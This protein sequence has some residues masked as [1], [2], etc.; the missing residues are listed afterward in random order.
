MHL[1]RVENVDNFPTPAVGPTQLQW[2]PVG[3]LD[4]IFGRS[5][6]PAAD[7]DALFAV[8]QA[9]L[10]LQAH[11]HEPAGLGSLCYRGSEGPAF[12]QAERDV[13]SLLD[14]DEGE[15]VERTRDQHGYS[16]L[17]IRH[18]PSDTPGLITDLHGANRGLQDAGFGTSLLCTV[19]N[20]RTHDE[21]PWGLVYLYKQGTFY[22]FVPGAE[23]RRDNQTELQINALIDND[24]PVEPRL[25]RWMALWGAPGL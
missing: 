3:F 1:Q 9:I 2:S 19:V 14:A 17:V 25:E 21:R 6:P 18:E 20:F 23:Q 4:S 10:S 16:W 12:A 24:V 11:G 15:D 5:K 13:V 22:P 7:L 8:P